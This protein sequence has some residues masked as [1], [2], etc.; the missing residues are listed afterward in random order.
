[1][2]LAPTSCE[3]KRVADRPLTRFLTAAPD[4]TTAGLFLTLWI[5]PMRFG[6]HGVRNA[7]LVMLVEFLLI[8]SSA[9]IGTIALAPGVRRTTKIGSIL[10]F[11]LFYLVFIAAFAWSFGE[12]WPYYAFGWLLAGKIASALDPRRSPD[13]AIHAMRSSWALSAL[14][15]IAGIFATL[16]LPMPR[17][18][19]DATV[20]SQLDLPGSGLWVDEPHTV[21]AFGTFYFGLLAWTKWRGTLLPARTLPGLEAAR[22][23]G[24]AGDPR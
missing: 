14:L 8:H 7:M 16:L 9:F 10:G 19:L 4:A 23:Q 3:P 20:V 1:M 18:G 6:P 2:Q 22:A 11:G 13:D 5:S 12:S 15:Y 24:K 21:I 17:F